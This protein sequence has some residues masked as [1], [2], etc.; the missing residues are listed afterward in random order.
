M[1]TD[2]SSVVTVG[3]SVGGDG[4]GALVGEVV[5]E[6]VGDIVGDIVGDLVG[7]NVGENVGEIVGE[8][9]GEPVGSFSS[10]L[11]WHVQIFGNSLVTNRQ[12]PSSSKGPVVIST[13]R[14]VSLSES[15]TKPMRLPQVYPSA[16]RSQTSSV[17]VSQPHRG[18]R[19]EVGFESTG[20]GV[21]GACPIGDGVGG[22]CP[23]GDGVGEALSFSV[24]NTA[25]VPYVLYVQK[26]S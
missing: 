1:E 26:P 3:P 19:F 20:E 16:M 12:A 6:N 14:S 11:Q 9:V 10:A 25:L 8:I 17:Q 23:I 13:P 22:A 21:G 5:G 2:W 4:V 18:V 24:L 15:L 7:E